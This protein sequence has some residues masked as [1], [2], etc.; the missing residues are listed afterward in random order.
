MLLSC[1]RALPELCRRAPE[2]V[3]GVSVSVRVSWV[4][5]CV[6]FGVNATALAAVANAEETKAR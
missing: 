5:L 6:F 2:C 4:C 3:C 1:V